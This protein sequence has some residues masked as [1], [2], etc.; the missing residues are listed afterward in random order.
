MMTYKRE[1]F[2]GKLS[3]TAYV[4]QMYMKDDNGMLVRRNFGPGSPPPISHRIELKGLK[5]G[6]WGHAWYPC[7]TSK[8]HAY[9]QT[10]LADQIRV[11]DHIVYT[12]KGEPR[13]WVI[14]GPWKDIA[15]DVMD[16]YLSEYYEAIDREEKTEEA[17]K[18]AKQ[19]KQMVFPFENHFF[20]FHSYFFHSY[21]GWKIAIY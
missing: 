21:L 1:S 8:W 4:A 17:E 9:R 2:K 10:A 7:N 14:D 16:E 13:G 5:F 18:A 15:E 11:D 6:Q 3:L 19:K 20:F 12:S